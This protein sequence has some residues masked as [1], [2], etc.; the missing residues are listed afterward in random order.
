MK[1][2]FRKFSSFAIIGILMFSG[3]L[4]IG[5][6]EAIGTNSNPQAVVE[7]T[8][9]RVVDLG[10]SIQFDASKSFDDDGSVV[11][12]Y[13]DF[14]DG[15][16]DNK[17]TVIHKYSAPGE[18]IVALS[19]T[20]DKGAVGTNDFGLT[21]ITVLAGALDE[22]SGLPYAIIS[23]KA[24]VIRAGTEIELNGAGSWSYVDGSPSTDDIESWEWDFGDGKTATGRTVNHTFGSSGGLSSYSTSGSYIV[25]L[26]VT[27]SAGLQDIVFRTIRVLS[28][29]SSSVSSPDPTVY[30]SVSIGD[31][32]TLDPAEAYDSASG[33]VL[34]NTYETLIYYDRDNEDKMIPLLAEEVPTVSNGGISPD[35][36]TYTFKIRSGIT[37]HDGSELTA[38]DV[39]FSINRLIIMGLGPSWM[40]TELLNNTDED[41]DGIADSIVQIDQSTVQF[42]LKESAPR[43][44][45]VMAYTA[46][47]IVSKDWVTS[48][49][50]G[51][52][53]EGVECTGIQKEVMG[54]GPYMMNEDYGGKWVPEQYVLMQYYPEYWRGWTDSERQSNGITAKGSQ[55]GYSFIQ[56]V[57]LKK[58]NDQSA[59]LLELKSGNADSV[60]VQQTFFEEAKTYD[61]IQW[62]DNLPSLTM[63]QIS[64]NHNISNHESGSAPSS[65]FFANVDVRKGFCY[66]FNYE[67]FINDVIDNRGIQPTGPIPEG[68][69]GYDANGP[70]YSYDP[71]MAEFHFKEAGVWDDGFTVDAYYNLGNDVRLNGLLLLENAL[72]E[73]NPKFDL[74]IQGLEWPLFLDKLKTR[75]IPIFMLGWGADYADPHNFA[76]PFLHGAE[77]YYPSSYLGFQF[78]DIDNLIDSAASETDISTREQMYYDLA[79]LEHDKALHIW[80]YQPIGYKI[81]KSWIDGWY[82]NSM[83]GTLFYTLSKCCTD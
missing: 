83:H 72:E 46:G 11:S 32:K 43:F 61:D 64:F 56:T 59:R 74:V 2:K 51:Y 41:G 68:L 15:N 80:V 8:G 9:S 7:V 14:G 69:L 4:G 73:L 50:C 39:V 49:G 62:E 16:N 29:E 18:Y 76:H 48:K 24:S 25:K 60:Y 66:S 44:L 22:D 37:F 35:G 53:S 6:E 78:D 40:Y 36:L 58:N 13:W 21:Y 71:D 52:P 27:N 17:E 5:T 23:T 55:Q 81:W 20:D 28:A 67:M 38:E 31:P 45:A 33:T 26:K 79:E 65:D 47:S 70:Q 34:S 19:V 57:L 42:T 3:C 63:L 12:Y 54:T 30:T 75:E 1:E 10:T 82:H 77:G